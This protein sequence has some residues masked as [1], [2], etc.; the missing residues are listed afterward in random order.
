MFKVFEQKKS[1]RK[2]IAEFFR[3][4][5]SGKLISDMQIQRKTKTNLICIQII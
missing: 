1:I 2:R 3:K 5:K 4:S